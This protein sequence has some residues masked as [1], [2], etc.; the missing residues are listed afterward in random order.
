MIDEEFIAE[1][2]R[3]K[4]ISGAAGLALDAALVDL[5]NSD[6]EVV[7]KIEKRKGRDGWFYAVIFGAL[8]EKS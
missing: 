1:R 4:F 3:H 7:V 8:E 6:T 2:T 5:A